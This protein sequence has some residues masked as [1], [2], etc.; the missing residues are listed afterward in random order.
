MPALNWSKSQ[1]Y[2]SL[3]ESEIQARREFD[4]PPFSQLLRIVIAADDP[5]TAERTL[6]QLAE[7]LS[8]YLDELL[9]VSSIKILGPAPCLFER[10]RGKYRM[11]LLIKNQAGREG[12]KIIT[13]FLAGKYF[14][15]GVLMAVDV[16]AVDLF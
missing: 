11:H 3:Y 6:E 1:D 15:E 7:S 12:Q 16:D 4:Y 9:P 10:L 5:L 14:Q 2:Q 13:S 8:H